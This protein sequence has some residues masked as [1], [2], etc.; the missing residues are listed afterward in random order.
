MKTSLKL[1]ALLF[2]IG[3]PASFAAEFVNLPLPTFLGS[4]DIFGAFVITLV[5]LL[6]FSDYERGGLN[7][8]V[9]RVNSGNVAV[10]PRTAKSAHALAA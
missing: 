10:L 9:A 6:A 5:L 3:L 2:A 7:E 4:A 8:T 1:M